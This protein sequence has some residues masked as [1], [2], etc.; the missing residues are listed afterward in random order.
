MCFGVHNISGL[1]ECENKL[2]PQAF[3]TDP[4]VKLSISFPIHSILTYDH[5]GRRKWW[6]DIGKGRH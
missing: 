4:L 3:F 5:E 6:A 2:R 1:T